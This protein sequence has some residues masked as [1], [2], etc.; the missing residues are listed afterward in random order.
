AP[1]R[2]GP[3]PVGGAPVRGAARRRPRPRRRR[4]PQRRLLRGTSPLPS[5]RRR[6]RKTS[7]SSHSVLLIDDEKSFRLILESALVSEGYEV[8]TAPDVKS[9]RQ[10]WR[11][12]SADLVIVDRN[13]PDGDG[14]DLLTDLKKESVERNLDTTFLV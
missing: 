1:G 12:A 8:R 11:Q 14:V 6:K 4:P 3:R 13:L 9:A 10:A 7:V 5:G 2:C